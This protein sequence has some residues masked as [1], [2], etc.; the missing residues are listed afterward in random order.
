MSLRS[1]IPA[2]EFTRLPKSKASAPWDLGIYVYQG[3]AQANRMK[4][5][6][7]I[8]MG[9][10]GK[11]KMERLPVLVKLHEVIEAEL[12]RGVSPNTVRGN[13]KGLA[14]FVS[15]IDMRRKDLSMQTLR[16]LYLEWCGHMAHRYRVVKNISHKSAYSVVAGPARI[17]GRALGYINEEPGRALLKYSKMTA[18]K[19][20]KRVLSAK[21]D[22]A[23]Q[24]DLTA[25]GSALLDICNGLSHEEVHRGSPLTLKFRSGSTVELKGKGKCWISPL[26]N[27][28]V[29]EVRQS[30]INLRIEAELLIFIAQTGMNSAQSESLRQCQYRWRSDGDELDAIRV[31]KGRRGGEV[32]FRCFREYR[33]HLRR[34]LD[35]LSA[36]GLRDEAELMFPFIREYDVLKQCTFSATK[37]LCARAGA[38]HF[39]PRSLRK[40]RVNWLLR[41]SRD[42]GLTAEQAA[43]TKETLLRAYEEPHHQSASIEIIRFHK[44]T[45]PTLQSPGPGICSGRECGPEAI[46]GMPEHAPEPDCVSPEGCLFCVHHRDVMSAD[47]CWKLTSHAQLKKLELSKFRPPKGEKKHPAQAVI[48]EIQLKLDALAQG[49]EIRAQWVRDAK[50]SVRSGIVHPW[51][52]GHIQLLEVL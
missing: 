9:E 40:A 44:T 23:K 27:D 35:W 8:R 47:Y 10:L 24:E 4:A 21:A 18:P 31:Y 17:V 5:P 34:Y 52:E 7:M 32:V 13:L 6:A 50:D 45:D 14:A 29:I 25:F 11:P 20:T 19:R 1:A 42:P 36:V 39:M 48:S 49:S 12:E 16:E 33:N 2:L 51:W 43:H 26:G 38:P 37:S 30:F 15:W 3:A 46:E 41:R 22:K 28:E